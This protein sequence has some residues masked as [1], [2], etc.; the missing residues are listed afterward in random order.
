MTDR[1]LGHGA[2]CCGESECQI[3]CGQPAAVTTLAPL[4]PDELF[5]DEEFEEDD[6]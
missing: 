1:A 3:V 4:S 2:K 5:A 6:E